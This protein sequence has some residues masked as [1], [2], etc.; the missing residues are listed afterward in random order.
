MHSSHG[1][2]TWLLML[3]LAVAAIA[4]PSAQASSRQDAKATTWELH[5]Q[6][7]NTLYERKE[8]AARTRAHSN[9][10]ARHFRHEDAVQR[11]REAGATRPGPGTPLV[12]A[13]G[14]FRWSYVFGGA[15]AA[16]ALIIL[17]TTAVIGIRRRSAHFAGS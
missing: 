3:S 2:I 14:G 15:G 7:E 13:A 8:A 17:G 6:H 12:A 11:T 5:W 10:I 1:H 16:F 9:L 4:L